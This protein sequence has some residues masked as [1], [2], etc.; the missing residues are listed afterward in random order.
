MLM[1]F[2]FSVQNNW[3][4]LADLINWLTEEDQFSVSAT[5]TGLE[6]TIFDAERV[7]QD[8]DLLQIVAN[9]NPVC[10]VSDEDSHLVFKFPISLSPVE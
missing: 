10:Y 6:F 1:K 9:Y 5:E 2:N 4:E 8:F 3:R 7:F